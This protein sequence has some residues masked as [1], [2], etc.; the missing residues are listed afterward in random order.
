MS[1]NVTQEKEMEKKRAAK[2]SDTNLFRPRTSLCATGLAQQ[3]EPPPGTDEPAAGNQRAAWRLLRT[4][5]VLQAWESIGAEIRLVGSLRTGLLAKHRDIDLHVYTAELNPA[6]SFRAMGRFAENPAVTQMTYRNLAGTPEECLE[7]HADYRAE[8][9]ALWTLD[10][11][12]IRKGSRY[13][14]VF[15]KIAERIEA[16]LTPETRRTI[17]HLKYAADETEHVMGIEYCRAV[18]EGGVSTPEEFR[19]WRRAHPVEGIL[20]WSP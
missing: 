17:L 1:G 18:I 13:D 12:Q 9:G 14:G 8:D 19:A 6:E 20:E 5:G 11:I 16:V 2:E 4:S 15:E 3:C 7:W 10:M